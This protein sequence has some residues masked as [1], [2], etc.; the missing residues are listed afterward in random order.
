MIARPF[1]PSLYCEEPDIIP[2][3]TQSKTVATSIA[4]MTPPNITFRVALWWMI[5]ATSCVSS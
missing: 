5:L 2:P 1:S 4:S 3:D